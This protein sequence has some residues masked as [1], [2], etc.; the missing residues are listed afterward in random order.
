MVH[1][2][3]F[4]ETPDLQKFATEMISNQRLVIPFEVR[5]VYGVVATGGPRPVAKSVNKVAGAHRPRPLPLRPA[6][7]HKPT[8]PDIEE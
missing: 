6:H 7:V 3:F 4:G 5:R 2:A 1:S 8:T